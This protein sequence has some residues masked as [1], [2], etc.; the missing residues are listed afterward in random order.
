MTKYQHDQSDKRICTSLTF[1]KTC[2]IERALW[3]TER[4]QK[5]LKAKRLT[6]DLIQVGIQACEMHDLHV[7]HDVWNSLKPKVIKAASQR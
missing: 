3:K 5:W 1:A 2:S 4:F 6:V 7:D